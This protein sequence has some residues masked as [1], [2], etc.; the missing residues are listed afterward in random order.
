MM[1]VHYVSSCMTIKDGGS[2]HEQLRSREFS[3][4][5]NSL[6]NTNGVYLM[7]SH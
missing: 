5:K 1:K 4:F 2:C 6:N 3:L 7:K